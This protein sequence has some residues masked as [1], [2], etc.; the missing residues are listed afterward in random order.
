MD[1]YQERIVSYR[2]SLGMAQSM[3]KRGIIS[4]KDYE[5]IRRFLAGKYGI[6]LS[7]IFFGNP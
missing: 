1:D 4:E 7:S 5:E 2:L 3:L 6:D